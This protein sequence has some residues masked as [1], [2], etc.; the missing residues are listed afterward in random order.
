[1]KLPLTVFFATVI[2]V[3]QPAPSLSDGDRSQIQNLVGQYAQALG[4][5]RAAEFADLF[6]PETG[7]FASTVRGRMVGRERLIKLVESERQCTTPQT[8]KGKAGAARPAPTPTLEVTPTGVRG[9]VSLG[10]AEY[11]DEYVKTPQGWR[12]ASRTVLTT[13][14]KAAGLDAAGIIAIQR[15]GGAKLGDHYEPDANG[16]SRLIT[17]GVRVNVTGDQVTGKAYLQDGRYDEQ[18]Y[19]KT[20]PGQ[21]RVKS[22]THVPAAAR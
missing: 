20:G 14:E 1:M 17:S 22:S 12:F 13:P 6:A 7:A 5:C 9:I 19:E 3:A 4:G 15:L 16:I 8:A 21:W 10:T 11:E 2:A 18:V